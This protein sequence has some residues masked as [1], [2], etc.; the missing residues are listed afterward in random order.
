MAK[1][2]KVTYVLVGPR[3]GK[4]FKVSEG[5]EF[6]KGEWTFEGSSD[7]QDGLDNILRLNHNAHPKDSEAHQK[8]ER[9]WREN[10][11]HPE[12]LKLATEAVKT[13][14]NL[15]LATETAKTQAPQAQAKP[16]APPVQ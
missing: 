8:A 1:A 15:K 11:H 10:P 7:Q 5:I 4:D 9:V 6:K 2:V 14:E 16:A 13:Q 12:N 3:A